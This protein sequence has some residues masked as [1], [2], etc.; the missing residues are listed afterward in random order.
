MQTITGTM[1]PHDPQWRA[2]RRNLVHKELLPMDER[3]INEAFL[4]TASTPL[5]PDARKEA[6]EL[7]RNV[8]GGMYSIPGVADTLMRK[9]I[10]DSTGTTSGGGML[11]RQD[12]EPFLYA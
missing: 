8:L 12:L 5:S 3:Q 4:T 1:H 6:E 9:S 7:T 11:I 2:K 10:L